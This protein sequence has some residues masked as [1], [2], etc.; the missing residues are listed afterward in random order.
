MPDLYS[1]MAGMKS[2]GM[3][4]LFWRLLKKS[5]LAHFLSDEQYLKLR[6]LGATG[7]RYAEP[8][9]GGGINSAILWQ[10]LYW[11]SEIPR[12]CCD[13]FA[14][15]EF[16]RSRGFGDYLVPLVPEERYWTDPAEIDFDALPDAFV[17]KCN[18]GSGLLKIVRNKSELK[19]PA[20]RKLMASWLRQDYGVKSREG[21]YAGMRN[22]LMCEQLIHTADGKVPVDY[23]FMCSNGRVL[24]VWMDFGRFVNHERTV[25]DPEFHRLPVKIGHENYRGEIR[26]PDQWDRMLQIAEGLSRGIPLVRVDLYNEGGRILFGEMTFTSD[27][28]MARV[29]PYSFSNEMARKIIKDV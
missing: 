1:M 5:G 14:V 19:V 10:Q 9:D 17:F 28:G 16:V 27:R 26:R 22:V 12:I 24:Y 2:R 13:K 8:E 25:F 21:Q 3:Q 20:M 11:K 23:K 15:R 29:E 18:N 4:K 6:L 7:E